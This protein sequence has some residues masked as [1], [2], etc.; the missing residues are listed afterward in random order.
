MLV[1]FFIIFYETAPRSHDFDLWRISLPARPGSLWPA[2]DIEA[3]DSPIL[4]LILWP[5]LVSVLSIAGNQPLKDACHGSQTCSPRLTCDT[6]V[7]PPESSLMCH[8]AEWSSL[9]SVQR[10]N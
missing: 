9:N 5:S 3:S 6:W 10:Q 1:P 7:I 8:G 2:K 4:A